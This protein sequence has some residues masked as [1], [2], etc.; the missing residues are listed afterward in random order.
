MRAARPPESTSDRLLKVTLELFIRGRAKAV[1]FIVAYAPTET[2]NASNKQAFWLTLDRAVKEISKREQLF[3]LMDAKARSGKSEKGEVGSR[4]NKFHGSYG[5]DTLNDNG[6]LLLSF[7]NN[8]DLTLVNK[9]LRTPKGGVLHTF[10]GQGKKRIGHIPTR[11]R[12]RKL[13]RNVTVHP[14]AL[15]SCHFRPQHCVRPFKVIGQLVR[16]RRM[17]ISAKLPVDQRRLMTDP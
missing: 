15:F 17:R 3:L 5:R 14:P 2:Q 13:V 7:A 11:Q 9:F 8:H 16:D 6:E 10:N 1:T 12:D 4:D